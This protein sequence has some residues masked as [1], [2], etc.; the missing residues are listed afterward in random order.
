MQDIR[1]MDRVQSESMDQAITRVE[2][3]QQSRR[4]LQ[5]RP[6]G[7]GLPYEFYAAVLHLVGGSLVEAL[8]TM[9]E[10]GALTASLQ[11]GVVRLLLKVPGAPVASQLQP[12]TLLSCDY[13]L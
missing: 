2:L 11:R 5:E 3:Q 10:R 12:I 6:L 8:N 4:R 1:A 13:K 9:L 7:S